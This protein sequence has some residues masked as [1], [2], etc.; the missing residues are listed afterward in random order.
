LITEGEFE[1]VKKMK[2]PVN[3][4]VL[5]GAENKKAV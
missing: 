5:T 1:V 3:D 2:K 4:E